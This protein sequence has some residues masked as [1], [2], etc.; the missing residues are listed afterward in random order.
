MDDGED[1]LTDT[2]FVSAIIR[3]T[4]S[5][6]TTGRVA[7]F[8][9]ESASFR[10][11]NGQGGSPA[12]EEDPASV[13]LTARFHL[14]P[15]RPA[16]VVSVRL[17]ADVAAMPL[18]PNGNPP[19]RASGYISSSFMYLFPQL[20]PSLQPGDH[21][22]DTTRM[23]GGSTVSA[24]DV[25]NEDAGV[26]QVRRLETSTA[27]AAV[28]TGRVVSSSSTTSEMRTTVRG[29]VVSTTI[30]QHGKITITDSEEPHLLITSRSRI[31]RIVRLN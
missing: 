8:V 21:W 9:V 15:G 20:R 19:G 4:E 30:A 24:W 13:G 6:S 25:L 27:D 10:H 31:A 12:M 14:V 16:A 17:G 29:P 28:E 26:Y 18:T 2:L 23:N 22:A 3:L 7:A 1:I 5:D 11:T